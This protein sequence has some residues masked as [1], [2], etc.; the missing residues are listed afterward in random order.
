MPIIELVSQLW[1]AVAGERDPEQAND[2]RT[3]FFR[4]LLAYCQLLRLSV[5][6]HRP[7]DTMP[8]QTDDAPTPSRDFPPNPYSPTSPRKPTKHAGSD[9]IDLTSPTRSSPGSKALG[10]RPHAA[11]T[12]PP[13]QNRRSADEKRLIGDY[14]YG[15]CRDISSRRG[16]R[17]DLGNSVP[18]DRVNVPDPSSYF[19]KP[20]M[21]KVRPATR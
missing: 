15:A 7:A 16:R 14:K 10:K 2:V 18:A 12:R 1:H 8:H 11:H 20:Q 17:A 21:V 4:L 3:T 13:F 5:I 6:P 19:S 9:T